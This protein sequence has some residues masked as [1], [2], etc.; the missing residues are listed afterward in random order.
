[1]DIAMAKV[2][3]LRQLKVPELK[4]VLTAL[5]LVKTGRKQDLIDRIIKYCSEDES[6]RTARVGQ[7]VTRVLAGSGCAGSTPAAA[8]SS[9]LLQQPAPS[10]PP[11]GQAKVPFAGALLC[12]CSGGSAPAADRSLVGCTRCGCLQHRACVQI[13]AYE[14]SAAAK[15]VCEVCRLRDADPAVVVVGE[16]HRLSLGLHHAHAAPTTNRRVQ[17]T[18]R[19]SG[20]E[21]ALVAHDPAVELRM[22]VLELRPPGVHNRWPVGLVVSV[23]GVEVDARLPPASW[24]YAAGRYKVRPVD[25]VCVLGAP[26]RWAPANVVVASAVVQTSSVLCVQLVR[27]LSAEQ[28]AGGVVRGSELNP[29]LSL[30][31]M[32]ARLLG[33]CFPEQDDEDLVQ[34][35]VNLSLRCPLTLTRVRTPVRSLL[36]GHTETF[37]LLAHVTS[38]LAVS[39]PRGR[40][41]RAAGSRARAAD[42]ARVPHASPPFARAEQV[43]ALELPALRQVG[44]AAR[45]AARQLRAVDPRGLGQAGVHRGARQP[46]ARVALSRLRGSSAHGPSLQSACPAALGWCAGGAAGR[47]FLQ[48]AARTR[49]RDAAHKAAAAERRRALGQPAGRRRGRPRRRPGRA[50]ACVRCAAQGARARARARPPAGFGRARADAR[51]TPRAQTGKPARAQDVE[52]ARAVGAGA[53][54]RAA[55]RPRRAAPVA[56]SPRRRARCC[57]RALRDGG[58]LLRL[59]VVGGVLLLFEALIVV[60]LLLVRRLGGGER[61]RSARRLHCRAAASEARGP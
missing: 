59:K 49:Q 44:A 51:A 45:A 7:I 3:D 57:G 8:S 20:E 26:I 54:L 38:Q 22:Y 61:A 48:A 28:L 14:H 1:M 13:P 21:L 12:I 46:A 11:A 43:P 16:P 31:A 55:T 35:A 41:T 47:R 33:R 60:G 32:R 56:R 37:D 27:R 40:P 19:L 9:P 58:G 24:D 36:C 53:A 18:L 25:E 2:L 23:N 15:H 52:A 29:A 34:T 4:E 6:S 5:S 50:A 42:R 30:E 17:G 10:G 39:A